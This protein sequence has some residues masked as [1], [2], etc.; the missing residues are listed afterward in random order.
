MSPAAPQAA[1][2][3]KFLGVHFECC[4]VYSRVY[5][6]R[7]RTAYLGHCPRCARQ[8]KFL[9]GA[10]GTDARFFSA[11]PGGSLHSTPATRRI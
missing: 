11:T 2:G 1:E 10:G 3:G 4:D 5:P 7:E 6:N 8:V 9:I